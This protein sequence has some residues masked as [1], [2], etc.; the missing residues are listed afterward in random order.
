MPP[1]DSFQT[2]A[3]EGSSSPAL[4]LSS[5]HTLSTVFRAGHLLPRR[6]AGHYAHAGHEEDDAAVVVVIIGAVSSSS[7]SSYSVTASSSDPLIRQDRTLAR[8]ES[9]T[10]FQRRR[11][12]H[13]NTHTHRRGI[14]I[15]L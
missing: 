13:T 8:T 7:Y 3:F 2:Y 15:T 10:P 4:S 1:Y 5:S 12:K 6:L 14:S 9:S 11:T